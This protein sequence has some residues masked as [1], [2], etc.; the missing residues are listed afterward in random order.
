MSGYDDDVDSMV[1]DPTLS[2]LDISTLSTVAFG[3]LAAGKYERY[4]DS[5]G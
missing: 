5:S 4:C 1:R 2:N 3:V